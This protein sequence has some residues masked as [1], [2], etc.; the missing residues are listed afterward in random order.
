MENGS[1]MWFSLNIKYICLLIK[2]NVNET[3]ASDNLCL[4]TYANDF[5]NTCA[6][7][8]KNL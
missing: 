6:F 8:F 2:M 3:G 5:L 1:F 7:S 4:F